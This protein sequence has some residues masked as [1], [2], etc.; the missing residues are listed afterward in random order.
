MLARG[1]AEPGSEVAAG[2]EALDVADASFDWATWSLGFGV[3]GRRAAA[4]LTVAGSLAE[5]ATLKLRAAQLQAGLA[6][7]RA[8]SPDPMEGLRKGIFQYAS[9]STLDPMLNALRSP[10]RTLDPRPLRAVNGLTGVRVAWTG[11]PGPTLIELLG[12]SGLGSQPNSVNLRGST[13]EPIDAAGPWRRYRM[14]GEVA[15]PGEASLLLA[16]CPPVPPAPR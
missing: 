16:P 1:D 12:P 7:R 10:L 3:P 2:A 8:P 9:A 6:A 14:S 4:W 15:E 11:S 13:L 5:S